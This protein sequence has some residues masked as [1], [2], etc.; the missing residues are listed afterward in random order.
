[1]R[2]LNEGEATNL[3]RHCSNTAHQRAWNSSGMYF[4]AVRGALQMALRE[5]VQGSALG[6]WWV[7]R[8]RSR[9]AAVGLAQGVASMVGGCLVPRLLVG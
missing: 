3:R 6:C 8:Q 7:D 5:V 1:M 9:P 4:T 2:L